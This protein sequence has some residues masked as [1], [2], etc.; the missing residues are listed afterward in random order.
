MGSY[1]RSEEVNGKILFLIR[2]VD[3]GIP[4]L[5]SIGFILDAEGENRKPSFLIRMLSNN[6]LRIGQ[7]L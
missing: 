1:R 5:N 4:R 7:F 6:F 3:T 2:R